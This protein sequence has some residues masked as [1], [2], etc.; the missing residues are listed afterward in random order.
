VWS[1]KKRTILI[2]GR[3]FFALLTLFA[4]GYQLVYLAQQGVL[5]VVNFFSYFTVKEPESPC[6]QAGDEW[7]IPVAGFM[8]VRQNGRV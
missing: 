5:D 8:P 7:P 4:L 2:A 1:V 6:F 3:L